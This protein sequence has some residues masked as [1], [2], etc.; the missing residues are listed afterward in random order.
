[1]HMLLGELE[2]S[3]KLLNDKDED[4]KRYSLNYENNRKNIELEL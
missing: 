4:Y 1:M 3:T 2:H